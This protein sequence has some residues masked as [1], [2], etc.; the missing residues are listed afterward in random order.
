MMD[1]E[2]CEK[3]VSD[4]NFANFCKIIDVFRLNEKNITRLEIASL[5]IDADVDF[6]KGDNFIILSVVIEKFL[7]HPYSFRMSV[8]HDFLLRHLFY[9]KPIKV[10][11]RMIYH[12]T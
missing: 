11:H 3:F 1:K 6:I 8:F 7:S 9:T 5:L 4:K 2:L 10:H 12:I